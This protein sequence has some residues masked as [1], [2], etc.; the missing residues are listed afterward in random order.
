VYVKPYAAMHR[1][2]GGQFMHLMT[3]RKEFHVGRPESQEFF[4]LRSQ[5]YLARTGMRQ[6]GYSFNNNGNHEL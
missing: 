1:L 3:G 4:P 6:N 5:D 2:V